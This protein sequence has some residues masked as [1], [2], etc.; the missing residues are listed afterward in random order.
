[1]LPE[2]GIPPI[3]EIILRLHPRF[4]RPARRERLVAARARR[5][6]I[7]AYAHRHD[8]SITSWFEEMETAAKSG[9]REFSRMLALLA[10]RKASGVISTR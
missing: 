7:L 6:A 10:D 1:M 9:R 8:L 3:Y 5:D 2:K 4:N